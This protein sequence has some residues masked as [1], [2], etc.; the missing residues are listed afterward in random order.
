M[1][2]F[3]FSQETKVV[4]PQ[5]EDLMKQLTVKDPKARERASVVWPKVKELFP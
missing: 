3:S 4:N 5:L 2:V 1:L